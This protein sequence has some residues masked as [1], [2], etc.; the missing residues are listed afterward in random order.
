MSLSLTKR[1][2]QVAMLLQLEW[3]DRQIAKDLELAEG[4]VHV[5]VH[6]LLVKLNCKDRGQLKRLFDA[7]EQRE[8][9]LCERELSDE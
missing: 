5:M 3:T 9:Q 2:S 6:N 7:E 1:Q 4:T 8:V